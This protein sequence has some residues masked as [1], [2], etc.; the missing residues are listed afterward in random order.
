MFFGKFTKKID[1]KF[2][3]NLFSSGAGGSRTHVQIKSQYAFYTLSTCLIVGY[4]Q[5]QIQTILIP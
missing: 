4:N 3:Y 5:V 1:C 2:F